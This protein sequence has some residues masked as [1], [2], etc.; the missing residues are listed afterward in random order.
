MFKFEVGQRW[1][2]CVAALLLLGSA[3][4]QAFPTKPVRIIIG[5]PPGGGIDIV[6]RMIQPKLSEGLGQAVVVENRPGAN[7]VLGMD[8]A[9]KA[10]H[11]GHTIFLGTLGNFSV[12]PALYPSLPFNVEKQFT[13][14]TQLASVSFILYTNPNVPAKTV[15]ELVA[16]A[17][18][19][20]NPLTFSSSG[21]GGLPHLAGELFAAVNGIKMT[22]IPY[23]GS[24]PAVAALMAG[25]IDVLFDNIPNILAQI[26]AGNV[27]AIAVTGLKPSPQLPGVPTVS[28]TGA[29]G[30]EV[31]VWFGMQVP[32][33]TP[34]AVVSQINRQLAAIFREPDITKRFTDSG[35][36]VVASTPEEFS[37]LL[38]SEVAKWGKVVQDANI[39]L[40]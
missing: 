36:Q 18:A 31:N 29:P 20:P 23:K 9:A 2:Q 6:A 39:T 30:F 7:G 4:V 17:K 26:K 37:Q 14:L 10:A 35:V 34:K 3:C 16:Y 13:P 27:L 38:K 1:A 15:P 5:F 11:D 25:E 19:S 24:A 28:E 21:S 33:A 12:N 8:A 22:H 40:E 32:A